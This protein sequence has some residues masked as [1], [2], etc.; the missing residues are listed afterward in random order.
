MAAA[1]K[2]KTRAKAP[3][4][5][6]RRYRGKPGPQPTPVDVL[7]R[8][9]SPLV[10]KRQT[11]NLLVPDVEPDPP[12]PIPRTA[13]QWAKL[14]RELPGFDPFRDADE[15]WFDREAARSVI[16]FFHGELKHFK[17]DVAGKPFYLE[18]WQMSLVANLFG[19]KR[20]DGPRRFQWVF[21]VAGRKNGK[22]PLAAGIILYLL[23]EDGEAGAELYS[24]AVEYRQAAKV[25]E[26]AYGM[27][28]QNAR[29][30]ARCRPYT[31]QAKALQLGA[32]TGFSFYRPI[33]SDP[34]AA[35]AFNTHAFVVDEVHAMPDSSLI[36]VLETSLANRRQPIALYMT[37]ADFERDSVCNEKHDYARSVRDE[38][39][40]PYFLPVI[41]EA[42]PRDDYTDPKVW[43]K[44]NP[45]IGVSVSR[46]YIRDRA[47]RAKRDD[48]YRE[49]FK[50]LH[51]C[52][53]TSSSL[54]AIPAEH[55]VKCGERK[56]DPEK[57]RGRECWG[58]LDLAANTHSNALVLIFPEDGGYYALS[59]FWLPELTIRDWEERGKARYRIWRDRGHLRQTPGNTTDYD[60]IR[61]DVN[62]IGSQFGIVDLAVDTLFQGLQ[63]C[64]DLQN[65]GFNVIS[66]RT[67]F[68]T[69]AAPTK[70]FRELVLS[71]KFWHGNHP[72][73]NWHA[74]N[75]AVEV[76][77]SGNMK[78][79]RTSLT[80]AI[81]GIASSIMAVGRASLVEHNPEPPSVRSF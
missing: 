47:K 45:N 23:F 31:G 59:W 16:E 21:M 37:T 3:A 46:S 77:A 7:K 44:A 66:F 24:A 19:W 15:C 67:G 41:F 6:K 43:D 64:T 51:L 81:D 53:R 10:H 50:R 28:V 12:P 5:A 35:H 29:L 9:G 42:D 71:H 14:L 56:V 26:Y 76:D 17:G 48:G 73:L 4:K 61:R 55:W 30:L 40:D 22:T 52:I 78:P 60:F 20:P 62:Q 63:L 13:G 69:M 49:T 57:L 11:H 2:S 1:R 36:E 65:D 33:P 8:R 72:V 39:G 18:R 38:G 70:A 27:L 74:A 34:K 75:T 79:C 54:R 80:G 25:F 68:Y 58:G 32:E